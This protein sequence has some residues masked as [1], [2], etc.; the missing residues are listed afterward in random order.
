MISLNR[1]TGVYIDIIIF[2]I[3]ISISSVENGGTTKVVFSQTSTVQ[4]IMTSKL[5]CMPEFGVMTL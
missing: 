2:L 5:T 1:Y 4:R 3:K